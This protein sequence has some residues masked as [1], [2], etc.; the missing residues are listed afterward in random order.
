VNKIVRLKDNGDTWV[1]EE[2]QVKKLILSFFSEVYYDLTSEERKEATKRF[3]GVFSPC[4]G[5]LTASLCAMLLQQEILEALQSIAP[6]KAS[7]LDGVDA[8][9]L[10]KH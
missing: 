4:S 7:G 6:L 1:D 5:T 8:H 9:F 2:H 10:Q 3:I